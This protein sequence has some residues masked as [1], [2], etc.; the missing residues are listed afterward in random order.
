MEEMFTTWPRPTRR[1]CGLHAIERTLHVHAQHVVEVFVGERGRQA[2]D[3]ASDIVDE[4]IESRELGERG[5]HRVVH[6]T[7]DG[8]IGDNRDH[9]RVVRFADGV[10]YRLELVRASGHQDQRMPS[11]QPMSERCT[12]AV[13]GSRNESDRAGGRRGNLRSGHAVLS[14]V[15]TL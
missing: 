8:D 6:L 5:V 12:D 10:G 1:K 2:G 7:A 3:A 11:G 4:Y 15:G 9:R 13:A 14:G